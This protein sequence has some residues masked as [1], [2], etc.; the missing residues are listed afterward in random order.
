MISVIVPAY[1]LENY[2]SRTLDSI[3]VQ[4]YND[5]EI[6]VV[7]DGSN[8][9]TGNIIDKYA[10]ENPG[11]VNAIHIENSGVTK[12]RLVGI[13][14]AQ[15]DWIGFVDG[16]DVIEA[17]MY[18]HLMNNAI[19][20]NAD[21][22]HCGYRMVFDDG[23]VNYFHNTGKIIEQDRNKGLT[24]LL[25]GSMVE[26]GLWNKLFRK[27]LFDNLINENLMD[28]NIK[29]NEDLLMNYILFSN[30]DK[31][32]F[33]DFCPYHYIVRKTSASR[34]NLNKIK[35]YDPIKV[36]R[37]IIELSDENMKIK[38]HQAYMGTCV[39]VYGAIVCVKCSKYKDDKIKVRNYIKSDRQW[40][41]LLGRKQK[42]LANMILYFPSVFDLAY[43]F[44]VN[45]IQKN[46]YE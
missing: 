30:A 23:R 16:D 33:E 43:K 19:Q 21:I 15:G 6:I 25:N 39:N 11:K 27:C 18:E 8:D 13:R 46:P 4:T 36:K 37:K 42:L 9:N 12:A 2:I 41:S 28:E 26:P 44:Y 22:S 17:D 1:N 34:Q 20:Y 7:N 32:V 3:L 45:H 31:S 5:I 14:E 29:I 24:D 38:A 40:I 10:K 35:I